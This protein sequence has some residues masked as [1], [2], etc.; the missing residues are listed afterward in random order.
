MSVLPV[1]R[2]ETSGLDANDE[3]ELITEV[4]A[5]KGPGFSLAAFLQAPVIVLFV[6]K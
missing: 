5:N 1:A 3:V 4:M 2:L 6:M